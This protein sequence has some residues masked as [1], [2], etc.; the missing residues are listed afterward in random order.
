[1]LTYFL[2]F[3]TVFRAMSYPSGI[4]PRWWLRCFFFWCNLN[5]LI[6]N[7]LE[8]WEFIT[9]IFLVEV[10]PSMWPWQLWWDAGLFVLKM[11]L[12][13][14]LYL[15]ITNLDSITRFLYREREMVERSQSDYG[16]NSLLWNWWLFLPFLVNKVRSE[17]FAF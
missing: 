7:L 6:R 9:V 10:A 17:A 1:M 14:V 4:L 15:S 16:G 8:V 12:K 3:A 11:H 13:F 5:L 2:S